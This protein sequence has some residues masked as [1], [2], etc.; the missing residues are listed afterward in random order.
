MK[1]WEEQ[2]EE[3]LE[4]LIEVKGKHDKLSERYFDLCYQRNVNKRK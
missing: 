2:Y 4:K 3:V 1:T